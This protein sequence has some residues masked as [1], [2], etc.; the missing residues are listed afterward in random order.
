MPRIW[1]RV[2]GHGGAAFAI[3]VTLSLLMRGLLTSVGFRRRSEPRVVSGHSSA[4]AW[5]GPTCYP[6]P[7]WTGY[8]VV[9]AL[10]ER[11]PLQSGPEAGDRAFGLQ[12]ASLGR[13]VAG[14]EIR[15][16]SV[17]IGCGSGRPLS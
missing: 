2:V 9:L 8:S 5:T 11:P 4:Q 10:S 1:L 17:W 6:E 7:P 3:E 16:R 15:T 14:L 13:A 12:N